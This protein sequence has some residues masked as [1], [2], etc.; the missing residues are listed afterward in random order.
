MGHLINAYRIFIY[1]VWSETNF[2]GTYGIIT[3]DL[4]YVKL[5][6]MN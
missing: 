4:T 3:I 1:E 5:K 6:R 2:W